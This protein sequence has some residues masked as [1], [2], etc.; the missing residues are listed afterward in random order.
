MSYE[1]SKV[2]IWVGEIPDRPRGF[3][4][5]LE[6]LT[7]AGANL[8]FVIARPDKRGKAVV[9]LAPLQGAAQ[10]QAAE[11]A[12]LTKAARMHTLRISGP[13]QSG[14]GELITRSVADEGLNLRGLSAAS[15]DGKSVTYLR[16]RNADDAERA[17]MALK[18]ALR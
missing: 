17:K 13:N 3:M 15:I 18:R 14:L 11:E 10:I 4:R 6:L 7:Q 9:F 1:I 16:F 12:L 5:K 8:E 2:D